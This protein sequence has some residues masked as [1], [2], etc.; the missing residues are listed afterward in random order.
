[1]KL[2]ADFSRRTFLPGV[3]VGLMFSV[4]AGATTIPETTVPDTAVIVSRLVQAEAAIDK[5]LQDVQA[6]RTYVL[7]NADGSKRTELRV[8]V[9]YGANAEEYIEVLE[10]HGSGGILSY[11]LKKVVESEERATREDYQ[12]IRLIP[13]NYD[14][15]YEKS[16]MR[17][18]HPCYVL[19][20]KPKRKSKYLIEGR[21]WVDATD[22]ALVAIEGRTAARVSI[23]AGKSDILQSFAKIGDLWVLSNNKSEVDAKIVG[24]IHLTIETRNVAIPG[25]NVATILHH[26]PA[27]D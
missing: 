15:E 26:D 17:N 20:L 2:P 24:R 4:A 8:R 19:T 14:F 5:R 16:E 6:M 12:K 22:F 1:M 27:L 11:A 18:G 23:W 13:E 21:A 3:A 25:A 7:K 10:E 9:R